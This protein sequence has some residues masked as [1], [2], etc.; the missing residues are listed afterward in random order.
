MEFNLEMGI[1][2]TLGVSCSEGTCHG[3]RVRTSLGRCVRG[4]WA[5]SR[6]H[7]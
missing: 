3:Q 2:A 4:G 6:R 5:E 1:P 7:L